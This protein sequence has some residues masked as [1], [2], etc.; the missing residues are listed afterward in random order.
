MS[1][2]RYTG[3]IFRDL[4]RLSRMKNN[5]LILTFLNI[6]LVHLQNMTAILASRTTN[7]HWTP[8]SLI[9]RPTVAKGR[10][11]ASSIPAGSFN[12]VAMKRKQP[13]SLSPTLPCTHTYFKTHCYA[14]PNI[15]I[16]HFLCI[17]TIFSILMGLYTRHMYQ[18]LTEIAVMW[19]IKYT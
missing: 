18:L 15:W 4:R 13:L 3:Y 16:T 11:E 7:C 19:Y 10:G 14:M 17:L 5:L 2:E 1:Y 6:I 8:G 9:V 12:R